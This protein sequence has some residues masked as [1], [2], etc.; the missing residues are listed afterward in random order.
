MSLEIIVWDPWVI[1]FPRR[2]P[3]LICYH[4]STPR[5]TTMEQQA[6]F[7]E[8]HINRVSNTLFI[9]RDYLSHAH[10]PHARLVSCTTLQTHQGAQTLF[11]FGGYLKNSKTRRVHIL[12]LQQL[13]LVW[14]LEPESF[15]GQY[16]DPLGKEL[17]KRLRARLPLNLRLQGALLEDRTFHSLVDS[18][19]AMLKVLPWLQVTAGTSFTS[20]YVV[21]IICL[22]MLQIHIHT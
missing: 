18:V 1:F 10:E 13:Y 2:E 3:Y 11:R 17:P 5:P 19:E 15:N 14:F 8:G 20:H 4:N 16:M 22:H 12:W 6:R 7:S 21:T 9:L